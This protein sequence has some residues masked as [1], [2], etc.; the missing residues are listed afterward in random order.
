MA[1]LLCPSYAVTG[2]NG[3]RGIEIDCERRVRKVV[4]SLTVTLASLIETM[5]VRVVCGC[6]G[7]EW[8]LCFGTRDLKEQPSGV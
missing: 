1:N 5:C 4:G 6:V 8:H 7:R 2:E 3:T